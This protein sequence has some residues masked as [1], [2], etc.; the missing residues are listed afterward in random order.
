[1][2]SSNFQ[3]TIEPGISMDNRWC[4]GRD[5]KS[6]YTCSHYSMQCFFFFPL[7]CSY[8]FPRFRWH[9]IFAEI[10]A[11]LTVVLSV[12]GRSSCKMLDGFGE[13]AVRDCRAKHSRN[14]EWIGAITRLAG[15]AC[16]KSCA[17]MTRCT[18]SS[19]TTANWF[20]LESDRSRPHWC[21][22]WAAGW[23]AGSKVDA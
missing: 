1:M 5:W 23:L 16:R 4:A 9:M 7:I 15:Q 20:P 13:F 17:S 11:K 6:W 10:F 3:P 19:Q 22:R 2:Q 12:D 8:S 21:N 14:G 18:R